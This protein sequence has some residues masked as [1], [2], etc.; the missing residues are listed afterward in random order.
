MKRSVVLKSS[1][2]DRFKS[3]I[4]S[5]RLPGDAKRSRIAERAVAIAAE[6][7]GEPAD[8]LLDILKPEPEPEPPAAPAGTN[9]AHEH[10][11]RGQAGAS[12]GAREPGGL[13]GSL[14]GGA[15]S[16]RLSGGCL[17][18]VCGQGRHRR[19]RGPAPG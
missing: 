9:A 3:P 4:T 16:G 17:V 14:R 13:P 11:R 8:D 12:L 18:H 15:C 1:S 10:G 2:S 19:D 6:V 7:T 5:F